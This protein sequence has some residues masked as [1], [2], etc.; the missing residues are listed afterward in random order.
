MS[1]TDN[2][3]EH[4]TDSFKFTK[5]TTVSYSVIFNRTFSKTTLIVKALKTRLLKA[6]TKTHLKIIAFHKN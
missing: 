2:T 4:C 5:E 3:L 6:D 1:V